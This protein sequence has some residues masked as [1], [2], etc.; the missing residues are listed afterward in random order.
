MCGGRGNCSWAEISAS[1]PVARRLSARPRGRPP[2]A[3]AA[4][5]AGRCSLRVEAARRGGA[6]QCGVVEERG[7]VGAARWAERSSAAWWRSGDGSEQRSRRSRAAQ[8]GGGVG[9]GRSGVA[10]QVERSSAMDERGWAGAARR[11]E[12]SGAA[13]WGSDGG[14]VVEGVRRGGRGGGGRGGEEAAGVRDEERGI[15]M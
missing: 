15:F 4:L 1:S 9:L 3:G 11:S 2:D 6:E 10:R 7:R 8:R 13:R 5:A 12:R 14:E